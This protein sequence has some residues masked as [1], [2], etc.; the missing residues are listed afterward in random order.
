[1]YLSSLQLQEFKHDRDA[2]NQKLKQMKKKY[3]FLEFEDQNFYTQLKHG[4]NKIVLEDYKTIERIV[5][6]LTEGLEFVPSR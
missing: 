6:G 4:V 2:Y 1:M 3:E 5:I